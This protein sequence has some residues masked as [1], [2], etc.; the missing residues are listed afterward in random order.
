MPTH[1]LDEAQDTIVLKNLLKRAD[2]HLTGL[3]VRAPEAT[4]MLA[5]ARS[6]LSDGPFWRSE[7]AGLALFISDESTDAYRLPIPFEELVF[8]GEHF[9]VKPLL[10]LVAE[11]GVF[12]VLALS[13]QRIRLLE[14][15]RFRTR[16][17]PVSGMPTSLAEA[18]K[19]D[20]WEKQLQFS[21][22]GPTAAAPAGRATMFHGHGGGGEDVKDAILR[23][24]RQVDTGVREMIGAGREP[25][26]LAGVEY[27]L[28]IYREANTYPMLLE[29]GVT[30]NPDDL[31][32]QTLHDRAWAVVEPF[33]RR[34]QE[35]AGE[36]YRARAGTALAT[37]ELKE[38][39]AAARYGRVD[40]LFVAVDRQCWGEWD[41]GTGRLDVHPS[42]QPGDEELL[43]SATAYT[44]AH[45]GEVFAMS[46][47]DLPD[48]EPV[49][50]LLR[51]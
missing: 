35:E 12:R 8:V 32:P 39:L 28:A 27:L 45:G 3:G 23:Y 41:P 2:E 16:E 43:D 50:A 1:P 29:G 11:D 26:V 20:V 17:I 36:R 21:G 38:V 40:T 6:L 13:Q 24:F 18:L 25:L 15:T 37:N 5:E 34:A 51:Y 46:A 33:F 47:E 44:V 10:P 49:A 9:H 31:S 14:G 22:L 42:A 4:A 19:Y 7:G 30:G 48:D